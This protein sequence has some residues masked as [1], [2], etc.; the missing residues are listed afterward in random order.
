MA[1]ETRLKDREFIDRLKSKPQNVARQLVAL[2]QISDW[3]RV[4]HRDNF[5]GYLIAA[6]E[7]LASPSPSTVTDEGLVERPYGLSLKEALLQAEEALGRPVETMA[8]VAPNVLR[9]IIAQASGHTALLRENAVLR[10]ACEGAIGTLA[11]SNHLI[12]KYT[13]EHHWLDEHDK[14]IADL[15]AAL[16]RPL[17]GGEG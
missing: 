16:S 2:T 11:A 5:D 13:P 4:Q 15:R 1:E 3:A 17:A 7:L 14:R 9:T 6:A 12:R 8:I 10:E